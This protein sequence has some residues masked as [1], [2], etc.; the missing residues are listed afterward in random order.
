MHPQDPDKD[1][2]VVHS[3]DREI[4]KESSE[5]LV[6][7]A[8]SRKIRFA[9]LWFWGLSAALVAALVAGIVGEAT[10]HLFLPDFPV[11]ANVKDMNPYER[12]ALLATAETKAKPA[13]EMKNT[14]IAY[15][16]LGA[17]LAGALGLAGALARGNLRSGLGA[18]GV[19]ILVGG[20]TGAGISA[21]F[22]PVFFQLYDPEAGM[23]SVFVAHLG[24]FTAI[25][26]AAGLGL[27]LGLKDRRLMAGAIFGGVL[28]A[29]IGTFV[30]EAINSTIFPLMRTEEP[31]P[32]E[33]LPRLLADFCVAMFTAFFSVASV[34]LSSRKA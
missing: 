7:R 13:S 11:P 21:V 27:G 22:V 10:Y 15:G 16:V 1:S 6:E 29:L 32:S 18:V 25:G 12:M 5:N 24:I 30:F 19:G 31:I 33:R 34:W 26:A 4:N 8:S 28:G 20:I 23:L 17:A 2:L 14:M 9:H 3:E